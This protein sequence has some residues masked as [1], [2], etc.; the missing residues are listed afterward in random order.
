MQHFLSSYFNTL[1]DVLTARQTGSYPGGTPYNGYTGGFALR[2]V[3][4]YVW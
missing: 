3:T 4:N 2:G 1:G